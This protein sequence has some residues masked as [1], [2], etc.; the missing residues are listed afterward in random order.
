[1]ARASADSTRMPEPPPC[2]SRARQRGQGMSAFVQPVMMTSRSRKRQKARSLLRRAGA[3]EG[4]RE[5]RCGR[6]WSWAKSVASERP[7]GVAPSSRC[8]RWCKASSWFQWPLNGQTILRPVNIAAR[9][10][11]HKAFQWPLIG[12]SVILASARPPVKDCLPR[13]LPPGRAS[14]C[15]QDSH[16][17]HPR[18]SHHASPCRNPNPARSPTH[19]VLVPLVPRNA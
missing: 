2:V 14:G 16:A 18:S 15:G 9:T 3:R 17:S 1:M 19:A 12:Q 10:H 7:V 11:F 6:R 8:S 5:D 4:R 13:Q